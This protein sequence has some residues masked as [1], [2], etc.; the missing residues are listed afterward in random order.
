MSV[1]DVEVTGM[2]TGFSKDMSTGIMSGL[3]LPS[4]TYTAPGLDRDTQIGIWKYQTLSWGIHRGLIYRRQC[5][6][7]F[8]QAR[9]QRPF[10]YSAAY[11]PDSGL[12]EIYKPGYQIDGAAGIIY[13]NFY[14]VLGFDKIARAGCKLSHPT[15]SA[16]AA[17]PPICLT[18][19]STG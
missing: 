1:G 2:Y 12:M 14:N 19:V 11:N 9:W 8:P 5:L 16:T 13:N 7:V 6:A 4:G 3:K 17:Q 15:G 10:L 18:A